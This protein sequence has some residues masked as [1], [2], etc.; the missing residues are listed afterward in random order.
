MDYAL[1]FRSEVRDELNEAYD[2]Y[3]ARQPGLGDD[4]LECIDE[5]LNQICRMPELY[6]VVHRDIRR[7]VLRRFPYAIYYRI[8]SSRIIV[9]AVF[10]GRRHPK[11]WRKRN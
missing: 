9:I 5:L 1:V 7:A 11:D 4:F 10:H 2:W 3:E 6:S 8:V